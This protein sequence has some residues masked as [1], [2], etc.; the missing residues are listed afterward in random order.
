M[1]K[2]LEMKIEQLYTTCLAQG[3]YYIS[4]NGEVAII[5]GRSDPVAGHVIE[6]A[7]LDPESENWASPL[8]LSKSNQTAVWADISFDGG[9]SYTAIWVELEK[10]QKSWDPDKLF[11]V[12]RSGKTN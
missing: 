5:W 7:S 10:K 3:A 2:S 11:V 1:H 12:T 8:V 4:S 9:R 6:T